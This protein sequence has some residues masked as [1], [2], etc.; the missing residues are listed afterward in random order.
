AGVY[1]VLLGLGFTTFILTLAVVALAAISLA[2]GDPALG[3]VVGIGFGLGRLVPV[4][5]LAATAERRLGVAILEVMAQRPGALRGARAADGLALAGCAL[6]IGATGAHAATR[7]SGGATDPSA[8]GKFL[9]WERPG[10]ASFLHSGRVTVELPGRDA[11]VGGPYAA[12]HDGDRVTVLR[13]ADQGTVLSRSIPGV[14]ELAVSRSWLAYRRLRPGRGAAIGAIRLP[15]GGRARKVSASRSASALGRPSLAGNRLAYHVTGARG[16][17][18]RLVNL[19]SRRRRTVARS[20]GDQLLNPALFRGAIAY[21]VVARCGQRVVLAHR[22]RRRT[23][24]RG[25]P[26]AG[27][28]PGFDPGHTT[29]GSMR[30]CSHPSPT[31]RMFWTTALTA[32][33]AYVAVLR[34]GAGSGGATLVRVGY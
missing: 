19:R 29:Q 31:T 7:V 33:W 1:G 23:L 22:G 27:Q 4:V 30:P 26:L 17:T 21:V 2:L 32:H 12:W 24:L 11:A 10:G 5:V 14:G 20:H 8:S 3:L 25:K 34:P 16:S 6:L 15:G 28:D 13:L 9:A 18:I